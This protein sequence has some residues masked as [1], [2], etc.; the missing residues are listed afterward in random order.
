MAVSKE[1]LIRAV[2]EKVGP[3]VTLEAKMEKG[4]WRI[5]LTQEAKTAVLEFKREFI[6]DF[7]ERGEYQQEMAFETR[8]Q[9]VLRSLK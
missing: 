7:F 3:E 5:T 4:I 1:Q 6:E 9:K 8:I 2:A